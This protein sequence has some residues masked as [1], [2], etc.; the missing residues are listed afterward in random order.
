MTSAPTEPLRTLAAVLH[1]PAWVVGGA[2][3]DELLNRPVVDLDV[4]VREPPHE[5]A[6]RFAARL[7]AFRFSLSEDF[8]SWRLVARDRAWQLDLLPLAGPE[9]ADDLAGRDLTINAIARPVAGGPPID[10]HGGIADLRAG[11]LRMVTPEAFRADPLRVMRLARLQ[12]ELGFAI[13]PPTAAAA[14][15]SAPRLSTVAPERVLGELLRLLGEPAAVEGMDA[16]GALGAA[17]AVLPELSALAGVEQSGYHH[18]D[19]GEHTRAVLTETIALSADP[20]RRFGGLGERVAAVLAEPLAGGLTRG[21]ALRLGALLHDVAKPQTRAETP[22]GRIT[23]LDHDRQGAELAAAILRRLRAPERVIAFVA[24]LVRHHLRAGFLVHQLPLDRRTI[25]G[26]LRATE[27][28][29]VE[30]TLL[31]VADRLAT[32]GRGHEG[33]IAR[34]LEVAEVLLGEA[35]RWRA[36]R[37]APP[38]R[39]DELARELALAP[40]P[41]IGRLL[42]ELEQ[43]AFAGEVPDRAAAFALAR[44]LTGQPS[45]GDR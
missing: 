22:A 40:G 31:S 18:L 38:V 41:E 27:P 9:L 13:D 23:F 32:R 37:P 11:R 1:E 45:A 42:G 5:L 15:A 17:E 16:L 8:G 30:V 29:E 26:Y 33:A 6:R 3:R 43:A 34:H 35:L 7:P 10:P 14:R 36:A 12:C 19:V 25:Y 24:G 28:V 44:R 4:A 21:E 39:G 20:T 2:V